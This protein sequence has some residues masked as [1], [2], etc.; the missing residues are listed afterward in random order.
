MKSLIA[1]VIAFV[2]CLCL[3]VYSSQAANYPSSTADPLTVDLDFNGKQISNIGDVITKGPWVDVRAYGAKGDGSTDDASAIQAALNAT[4]DGRQIFFP[5]GTYI[6]GT[7]LFIP[8]GRTLRGGGGQSTTLKLKDSSNCALVAVP[9]TWPQYN[10]HIIDLNFDGNKANQTSGG[11]ALVDMTG[12]QSP[13]LFNVQIANSKSRGYRADA[14]ASGAGGTVGHHLY[15][16][17][18][19]GCESAGINMKGAGSSNFYDVMI[20]STNGYGLLLES[21]TESRFVGVVCDLNSNNMKLDTAQFNCFTNCQT[22]SPL[23][24]YGQDLIIEGN[25]IFNQ[26]SNCSF[27]GNGAGAVQNQIALRGSSGVT[28]NTFVNCY[29]R[30]SATNSLVIENQASITRNSFVNC[31]FSN[32]S[33]SIGANAIG[34]E[35]IQVRGVGSVIKRHLSATAVWDPPNLTNGSVASTTVTVTGAAV[36]DIAYAAHSSIGANNVIISANVQAADT[37]RVVLRN[38]TGGAL[39]IASGTLRVNVWKY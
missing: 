25:S 17:V 26:F 34:N 37:V 23:V 11:D 8:G 15:R 28:D 10:I 9:G 12:A 2:V 38:D 32:A 30:N 7:T 4:T 39:D 5:S 36:G 35:F 6:V 3:H 14:S 16:V 1:S 13:L 18:V 22:Y 20:L 31:D 19:A 24:T 21:H 29:T 27:Q 33:V